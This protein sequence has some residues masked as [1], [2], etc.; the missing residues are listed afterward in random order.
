MRAA[1][2][3]DELRARGP[4]FTAVPRGRHFDPEALHG[5]PCDFSHKGLHVARYHDWLPRDRWG[6]AAAVI[7][8]AN[9]AL[10]LWELHLDGRRAGGRDPLDGFVA[11]ADWLLD[12]A[13]DGPGGQVW[14]TDVAVPKYGVPSGWVSAMGQ[15]LAMSVLVRAH[16]ETGREDHLELARAALGPMEVAVE[17]GGARRT[18]DGHPVLEEYPADRPAAILNGWIFALLGLHDLALAT[19]DEAPRTLLERS[20]A[21]LVE[22]L[23]RYD[24]GWWS[25]YSLYDHGARDLAKPFYQRLHPLLL[26]ALDLIHAD[27]RLPATARRWEAQLSRPAQARVWLDKVAFRVRRAG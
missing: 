3:Y 4:W 1:E 5:Y 2:A 19:G 14:R 18:I 26:D 25:L 6:L 20:A 27:P 7:P 15:G 13:E 17:E 8:V 22:L 12:D 23:P 9:A 10:G 11:L 24:V 21:G 16:A